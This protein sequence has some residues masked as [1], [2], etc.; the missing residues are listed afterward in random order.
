MA[1]TRERDIAAGQAARAQ[2][3]S[4]FLTQV[5]SASNPDVARGKT[6]TAKQLLDAGA[7]RIDSDLGGTPALRATLSNTIGDAYES[8]GL[9]EEALRLYRKG[10]QLHQANGGTAD[11][12]AND[13]RNV[14]GVLYEL[15]DTTQSLS[16]AHQALRILRDAHPGDHQDVAVALNDYG[17]ALYA[18]G[19]YAGAIEAYRQGLDMLQRLDDADAAIVADVQHDLGQSMMMN[20]D[21]RG[22]EP[23][24]RDAV[25]GALAAH[26][27]MN[28]SVSTFLQSLA[29]VLGQEGRNAEARDLLERAIHIDETIEPDHPDIADNLIAL[30][31]VQAQ[32]GDLQQAEAVMRRSVAHARRTRGE[33]NEATAYDELQLANLLTAGG[34]YREAGTLYDKSLATYR[35]VLGPDNPYLASVLLGYAAMENLTGKPN[36]ALVKAR[37][38]R[39]IIDAQLPPGHWIGASAD[40]VMGEALL[41]QG[42]LQEAGPLLQNSYPVLA[43]AKPGNRATLAALRRLVDYYAKTGDQAARRRY[44]DML[45]AAQPGARQ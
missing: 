35:K 5:F 36:Q 27:E 12:I 42:R 29:S 4:R 16:T 39:R 14:S 21:I 33:Q 15:D 41:L 38:A 37:E 20:G 32:M 3:V 11:E 1:L 31:M 7:A 26:G 24:L 44:A 18:Q 23:V 28:S 25:R 9:Y 8:L 30:G 45:A 43:Q 17:H 10:L 13:L 40:S 19:D 22:A 34:K 2:A 6:P